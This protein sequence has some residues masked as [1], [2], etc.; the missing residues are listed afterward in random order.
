M[1]DEPHPDANLES[2]DEY[3][4]RAIQ[5]CL[6]R[7]DQAAAR[8]N[9]NSTIDVFVPPGT[10]FAVCA[11][12]NGGAVGTIYPYEVD[13]VIGLPGDHEFSAKVVLRAEWSEVFDRG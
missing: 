8:P 4:E 3:Q 13:K 12:Q 6:D 10:N 11:L 1:S 2:A 9:E 7:I 5:T